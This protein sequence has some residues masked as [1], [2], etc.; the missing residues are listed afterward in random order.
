MD[1]K[2]EFERSNAFVDDELD[3][4]ARGEV[5]AGAARDP[6]L[7]KELSDLNR[8]KSMVEDS[9]DVPHMELPAPPAGRGRRYRVAMAMATGL[10]LLVLDRLVVTA[11][12]GA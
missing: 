1:R 2:Q 5:L 7:A 9:V 3:R 4:K 11:V 12:S 8:L 10:A 6:R